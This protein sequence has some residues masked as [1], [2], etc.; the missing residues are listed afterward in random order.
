VRAWMRHAWET[1]RH[2]TRY[3]TNF[4]G[5]DADDGGLS[6]HARMIP[7]KLPLSL[8]IH[9][10]RNR[11]PVSQ[12]WWILGSQRKA[13][14]WRSFHRTWLNKNYL[15][16]FNFKML[17]HP[18][19]LQCAA[20]LWGNELVHCRWSSCMRQ[21]CWIGSYSCWN[22]KPSRINLVIIST[23]SSIKTV[24]PSNLMLGNDNT[25]GP[26][27]SERIYHRLMSP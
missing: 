22:N 16:Y 14:R 8:P 3:L 17:P 12:P 21:L 25:D 27:V 19:A 20:C 13:E 11:D 18:G 26:S 6:L 4:E 9:T 7:V 10:D 15:G 24:L 1:P 2:Q 23:K 5:L